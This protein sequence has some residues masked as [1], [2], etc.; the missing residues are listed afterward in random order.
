VKGTIR[1]NVESMGR[2]VEGDGVGVGII[3]G[4]EG[5]GG[6]RKGGVCGGERER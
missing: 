5:Y 2:D 6:G 1:G 3:E 4:A